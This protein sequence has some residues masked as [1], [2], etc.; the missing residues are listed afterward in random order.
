MAAHP[1]PPSPCN[2]LCVFDPDTGVCDGCGRTLEE[3]AEWVWMTPV[4]K[5]DLLRRIGKEPRGD[6]EAVGE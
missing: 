3:I 4:E 5:M 6:R 2:N 1:H